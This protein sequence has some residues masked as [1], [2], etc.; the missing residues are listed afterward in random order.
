MGG[1]EPVQHMFLHESHQMVYITI[2]H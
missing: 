1:G 2:G